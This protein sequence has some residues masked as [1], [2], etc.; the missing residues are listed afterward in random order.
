MKNS[1]LFIAIISIVCLSCDGRQT[2]KEALEHAIS[3]FNLKNTVLETFT[4]QPEAHVE[5]TTDTLLS[6]NIN[7]HIK[8]YSIIDEQILISNTTEATLKEFKYQRV[9]ESEVIASKASKDIFRTH[10]SAKQFKL[11]DPD[12]F[13]DSATL[14]HAWVNQDLSTDVDIKLDISFIN[15][16]NNAYKLYRMSI[17][18]DG[19]QTLKL[20]EEYS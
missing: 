14:Q 17:D 5:I 3:E 13:W 19:F 1:L 15:P 11:I 8:N 7:V 16:K 20:I 6:N 10:I 18:A 9:F 4:Y 2:K 12:R